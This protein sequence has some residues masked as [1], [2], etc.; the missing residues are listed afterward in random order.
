M[1]T[2]NLARGTRDFLPE[3]AAARH[4]VIDRLRAVFARHGFE[5]LETPAFER[6]ETLTG[7]Y[8]D[9]GSKLIFRILKRGEGA[10]RGEADQALRYDLTVPLAR[11]IAMNPGLRMPFKR[12]QI[13]PVWRADRP[14]KGRFREFWQCDCDVVG[15]TEPLADAECLATAA[16]ALRTLGFTRFT[17]RLNDRR[18]LRATARACGADDAREGS[19]LVAVDKLD[20]IGRDGV[21]KELR[22]RG[23]SEQDTATL[24]ELL[25]VSGT[26]AERLDTTA[27]LLKARLGE[28][29]EV[30]AAV[31]DLEAVIELAEGL[32]VEAGTLRIDPTLARGLDYYTGPV[33]EIEVDEP[34]VGALAG[35]GR[36]DRLIGIFGKQQVPAVGIALGLERILTVME[37]LGTLP[38]GEGRAE[39]MV[40]VFDA[41]HRAVAARTAAELRAQGIRVDLYAGPPKLKHQFKHADAIGVPYVILVGPGEAKRGTLT[42]KDLRRGEQIECTVAE[43]V[44]RIRG[45][46]TPAAK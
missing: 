18:L 20:K 3:Q 45:G 36:Y 4:A 22:E 15:S 34:K 24:W 42:L 21:E 27:S 8:G 16:D 31:A 11:V 14:A 32:G 25:S 46:G 41:E 23:F 17:I 7:K 43:A 44:A 37:E 26:N 30:D 9:E 12:W 19:L 10:E 2:V 40:G 13:A 39:V 33:F 29:A 1:E 6:I 5:P 38:V 35:G 28:V